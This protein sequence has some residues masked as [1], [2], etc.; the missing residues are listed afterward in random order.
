MP[1]AAPEEKSAP[2]TKK[3]TT[4]KKAVAVKKRGERRGIRLKDVGESA[5]DESQDGKE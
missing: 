2:P 1:E 3:A 4:R 5:S